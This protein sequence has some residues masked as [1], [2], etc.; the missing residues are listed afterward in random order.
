MPITLLTNVTQ[1]AGPG[2]L[3]ELLREGHSVICHDASFVDSDRRAHFEAQVQG[4][5]AIGE[6]SPEAIFDTVTQRW[7]LPDAVERRVPDHQE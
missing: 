4:A 5:R 2:A 6:Q 7:G 1:Y 3:V